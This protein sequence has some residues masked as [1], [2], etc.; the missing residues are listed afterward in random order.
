MSYAGYLEEKETFELTLS[1]PWHLKTEIKE[2]L[3]GC[4][5]ITL[6]IISF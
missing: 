1:S 3:W 4:K 5:A 2:N 6:Q